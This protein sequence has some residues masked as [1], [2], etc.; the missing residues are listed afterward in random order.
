VIEAAAIGVVLALL[1]WLVPVRLGRLPRGLLSVALLAGPVALATAL[2]APPPATDPLPADRSLAP[3]EAWAS[4]RA[5]RACHPDAWSTWHDS[6]HRTMTQRAS[7]HAVLAPWEGTLEA[8]GRTYHL[9]RDGERFL[10]DVPAP[11][12]TGA[13]PEDRRTVPVV[14]TTGSHHLQLYWIPLPWADAADAPGAWEA[15]RAHC[16]DCHDAGDEAAPVSMPR[17]HTVGDV[18]VHE[19]VTVRPPRLV[20]GGLTPPQVRDVLDDPAHRALHDPLDRETRA[21]VEAWTIQVQAPGRLQQFPFGWWIREGRWVHEEDTFLQPAE[22]GP[23]HEPWEQTWSEACDQ[24]HS[25][26]PETTFRP[27]GPHRDARVAELGIA[28]EACHGPAR[29]HA[30]R[31][32]DPLARYVERLDGDPAEDIVNPARL[33]PDRATAVCAQCHAELVHHDPEHGRFQVG[34]PLDRWARLLTY[35]TPPYP[36]WLQPLVDDDPRVL[37]NAF[38]RDGTLRVAGRNTNGMALSGCATRGEMSCLTCHDMHGADPDDQLRPAATGDAVCSECHPDV[39][40]AGEAHTH[41]PPDSPGARCMNCHMP[42][43]TLG[44]LGAMR[45]HRIDSPSADRAHRTG[46]PDACSLCHLDRPLTWTAGHLADWYGQ[47]APR[48]GGDGRAAAVDGL[49]RGDAAQ[50]A[51]WAWHLGWAPAREASGE[52]WQPALLAHT[53]DDPYA[54]VRAIAGQSL[55]RHPGYEGV[56]YDFTAPPEQRRARAR[57]VLERWSATEPASRPTV[58]VGPD[59]LDEDLIRLMQLVRDDRPVIV[60]E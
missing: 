47:P 55:K 60:A 29:A 17:A 12:T 52:D 37:A 6:Y 21:A 35:E 8:D 45:S 33:P 11:G 10:V 43:T 58:L 34:E 24:C 38:W 9:R 36:D 49:L 40:K 20:G 56:D 4:S 5:C 44:L 42:H 1:V 26:G 23:S 19:R 41:H 3:D 27:E 31:Y 48:I 2:P 7:P 14:M 59:G 51:V 16:A 39:A 18:Q 57:E 46:R 50:R 32:R 13:S 25:V 28:C 22:E 30:E 15:F 53:L 54:A